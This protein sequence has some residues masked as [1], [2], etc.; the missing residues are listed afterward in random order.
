LPTSDPDRPL[1]T[2]R[3]LLFLHTVAIVEFGGAEGIR[4]RGLLEAAIERP[5]A[6]LG[7]ARFYTT[8]F[9]RAAALME[10]LIRHHGF[11]DGNKRTAVMATAFWLEREGYLLAASQHDVVEAAVG[12]A[13]HRW[14]LEGL[15]QW[16]KANSR[17]SD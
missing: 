16:L 12:V 5:L 17:P 1:I 15:A 7:G 11:V 13:E 4:D 9:S 3:Q 10:A 2:L 14:G 8:P 6:G